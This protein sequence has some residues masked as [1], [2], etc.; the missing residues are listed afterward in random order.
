MAGPDY[1]A[2]QD[3]DDFLQLLAALGVDFL[4]SGEEKV[5]FSFLP[6][7]TPTS[8]KSGFQLIELY[9][10]NLDKTQQV[11]IRTNW[12][13]NDNIRVN[14]PFELISLSLIDTQLHY[15]QLMFQFLMFILLCLSEFDTEN[16]PLIFLYDRY[17]QYHVQGR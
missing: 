16:D 3:K 10:R 6:F 4:L 15:L 1:K 11:V 8:R 14:L 5:S 2:N 17:P 9:F 12:K 13:T 7:F